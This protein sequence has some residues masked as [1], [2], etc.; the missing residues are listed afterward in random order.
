MEL[1]LWLV[2]MVVGLCLRGFISSFVNYALIVLHLRL[3]SRL[4]MRL[5]FSLVAIQAWRQQQAANRSNV[6]P[7]LRLPPLC[8]LSSAAPRYVRRDRLH[9]RRPTRTSYRL[10]NKPFAMAPGVNITANT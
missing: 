4:L 9:G 5:L 7:C 2:T 10:C 8:R 1:V 6:N 3:L